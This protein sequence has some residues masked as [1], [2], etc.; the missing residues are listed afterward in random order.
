MK[1]NV[2]KCH[3]MMFCEINDKM[4][5]D[6]GEAVIEEIN[7]DTLP[8][9]ALDTKLSFQTHLQPVTVLQEQSRGGGRH[10]L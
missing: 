10:R 4:Q 8:G 7:E 6:I 5:I 2:D 1:L 3:L 9:I